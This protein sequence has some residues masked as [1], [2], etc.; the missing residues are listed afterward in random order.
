MLGLAQNVNRMRTW[1]AIAVLSAII[2]TSGCVS[3]KDGEARILENRC[4]GMDLSVPVPG[5]EGQTIVNLKFGWVE[6]KY[7]HTKDVKFKSNS[8]HRDV[9]LI[10]GKGNVEREFE[11]DTCRSSK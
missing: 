5:V 8:K 4:I 7:A 9:E 6:T 3:I 11:I 2:G 1:I 10:K